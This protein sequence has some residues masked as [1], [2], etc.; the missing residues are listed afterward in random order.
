[1]QDVIIDSVDDDDILRSIAAIVANQDT[2]RN[3]NLRQAQDLNLG[4]N[5]LSHGWHNLPSK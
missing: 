2:W 1:M 5:V 4:P 3:Q